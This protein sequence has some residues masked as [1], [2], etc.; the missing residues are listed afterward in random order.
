MSVIRLENFSGMA[1]SANDSYIKP[2]LATLAKNVDLRF[3]DLR[4]VIS[5]TTVTSAAAGSTLYKFANSNTFAT[6]SGDVNFVRGPI[7]NDATE[8]TYYTGDGF[9]KVTDLTLAVRQLGVPKPAS[10]P[11]TTLVKNVSFT[12][13]DSEN[14]KFWAPSFIYTAVKTGAIQGVYFGLEN[15]D[16]LDLTASPRPWEFSVVRSGSLSGGIFTPTIATDSCLFSPELE[17]VTD[18]STVKVPL[19]VRGRKYKAD[20]GTLTTVLT[21]IPSP[22]TTQADAKML[23]AVQVTKLALGIQAYLASKDTVINDIVAKVRAL[24][25]D[26]MAMLNSPGTVV[27]SQAGLNTAAYTSSAGVVAMSNAVSQTATA[28]I[29]ASDANNGQ[30]LDLT[31]TK[32]SIQ[33]YVLTAQSGI[34]YV[35]YAGLTAWIFSKIKSTLSDPKYDPVTMNGQAATIAMSFSNMVDRIPDT[36]ASGVNGDVNSAVTR[37]LI[38]KQAQME[39]LIKQLEAVSQAVIDN[40]LQDAITELFNAHVSSSFP[41]GDAIIISARAYIET[42]VTDW[43]EESEPS[44][45]SNIIQL[46]QNDTSTVALSAAPIG[47]NITKRRLYRSASGSTTSAFLLQGEYPAATVL[48]NDSKIDSTLGE[49]C[50]TFGWAEPLPTLTGLAGMPN[51]IMLGFTGNTL[52]AC[53]PYSPYAW[54]A[55][56][57]ITLEYPIVGIAVA[58]QTAIVTTTGIPYLVTG[59][60]SSSLSAEKMPINQSCIAKRS[61]VAIG[62]SVI[63]ASP[64]GLV[65]IENFSSTVITDGYLSKEDW[66]GYNPSSIFAAEYEGRYCAFY[67]KVNG[68]KG[69]LVF[70]FNARSLVEMSSG[71][72]AVFSDRATDTLYVLDGTSIKNYFP[73]SGTRLPFVWKSKRFTLPNYASFSWLS[74]DADFGSVTIE[75][76]ANG[77]LFCAVTVNNSLPVRLPC[78][79]YKDWQ[80]SISSNVRVTRITLASSTKEL[81]QVA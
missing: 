77:S 69:C 16:L 15:T 54:P 13:E 45:V 65:L 52:H 44:A 26:F 70:D 57:D 27:S 23:S 32:N 81:Q 20:N 10:A 59:V 22:D 48:V 58:G 34:K 2:E 38:D 7:P 78:G 47:R 61:M 71:A 35:D 30:L 74:V 33:S 17:Y 31:S 8:R 39:V 21:A 67:T 29:N 19:F 43:G 53:E 3:Q 6:K 72:D 36:V 28:V 40:G 24:K 42:F 76:Y 55:A 4:P 51:G 75:L 56:Y 12:V 62:G 68:N 41:R 1:P 73:T 79:R 37:M 14:A 5:P 9:P 46:D 60:D 66:Q 63:Y 80:I 18:N 49:A 25:V 64:D 11:V 50:P